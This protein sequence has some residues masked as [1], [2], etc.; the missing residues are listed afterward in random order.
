MAK[1][2]HFANRI[3]FPTTK[4]K[5]KKIVPESFEKSLQYIESLNLPKLEDHDIQRDFFIAIWKAVVAAWG[6]A[7]FSDNC[8]LTEKVGIFCMSRYLVDR[9]SAMADLDEVDLDL[10]DFSEVATQ[11]TKLAGSGKRMW[12]SSKG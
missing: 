6:D 7:V 3:D 1:V 12:I 10:S 11:V 5:L 4:G 9:L 2:V 8:K